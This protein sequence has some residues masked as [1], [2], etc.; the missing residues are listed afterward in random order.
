MTR[1]HDLR[2]ERFRQQMSLTKLA[3]ESKTDRNTIRELEL[4][5]RRPR[6]TTAARIAKALDVE[7]SEVFDITEVKG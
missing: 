2:R 7:I 1:N 3:R 5:E 4:G 6:M